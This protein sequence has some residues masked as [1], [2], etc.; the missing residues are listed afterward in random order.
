MKDIPEGYTY[1]RCDQYTAEEFIK[2][3]SNKAAKEIVREY[4]QEHPKEFYNTDDEIAVHQ[5][6]K[7]RSVVSLKETHGRPYTKRYK[8]P[9]S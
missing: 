1:M 9:E 8:Y 3:Y 5:M 4:T 7:E 2:N 6:M